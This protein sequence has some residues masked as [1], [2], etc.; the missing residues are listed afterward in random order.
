[1]PL[2]LL[3]QKQN[4]NWL[5]GTWLGM[6]FNSGQMQVIPDKASGMNSPY[7]SAVIS[8][9]KTGQLLC[10]TNGQ[11][12]WNKNNKV[13]PNGVLS[14]VVSPTS[15]IVPSAANSMQYYIFY[16]D[17]I[18]TIFYALVDMK[19]DNGLG[20]VIFKDSILGV[21]MDLQITGVR[22]EYGKGHWLITHKKGT[23]DFAVFALNNKGLNK[24][25]IVSLTGT[26][27]FISGNYT[28]GN[29]VTNNEGTKLIYT[30]SIMPSQG[31][32]MDAI[33]EVYDINKACGT[34]SAIIRLFPRLTGISD[35]LGSA[36]F[37]PTSK[38]VYTTASNANA[39]YSVEQYD[40]SDPDPNSTRETIGGTDFDSF[41][42]I[43]LAPDGRIYITI[44]DYGSATSEID[45]I[46][47][48]SVK[49]RDCNFFHR[50]IQLSKRPFLGS[51]YA[52]YFPNMIQDISKE[53]ESAA[54]PSLN[55]LDGCYGDSTLFVLKDQ[56]VLADSVKWDFGDG[57]FF[58]TLEHK[59]H[60]YTKTGVYPVSFSWYQCGI[61]YS[62]EDTVVIR[63]K[64]VLGFDNDTILCAGVS[65]TLNG[66]I[67][68]QYKWST[69]D[70]TR[71][72]IVKRPGVYSVKLGAT[73]CE[74]H[75]TISIQY[76]PD[77]W[78]LL[79]DEYFI[80][81]KENELVKLDAGEGF[82]TYKWLPT[83]D[84]TQW[85]NVAQ[86]KDYFV[87]VKDFRGCEGNDGTKVKRRCPVKVYFPNAFTPNNDNLNDVYLPIGN[88]VFE[89]NL[90]IY[91]AWG[92]QVFETNN[93][94]KGWDGMY[95]DE[96][97]PD[98]TYIYRSNYTG[99]RNKKLLSFNESGN[100]TLIR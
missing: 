58:A 7:R 12:V 78:T 21:G 60:T 25:P 48:P 71:E 31:Q 93:I 59:Y 34:I 76:R 77:I 99:Y 95:L 83:G 54:E 65:Y 90:T 46:K 22:Q 3:A 40:L 5:F 69:G 30:F 50:A 55:S 20:N 44:S 10:Y 74:L 62:V 45:V 67:A 19:L 26:A 70:I 1:M 37:D 79:G 33:T 39:A 4:N 66:G 64:P 72:I 86:I 97:A 6:T 63:I 2:M 51:I 24:T 29:L 49:G 11:K 88:D 81:D 47:N 41:G 36:C 87:I 75:D 35:M 17:N 73:G 27:T 92:Q 18:S 13:M 43:K 57:T 80:C 9:S 82:Q 85:I 23:A 38:F 91:N 68:D 84:T 52:E 61:A 96:H 98:G 42:D 56:P 100:I 14:S 53:N 32:F 8:D 15:L 94:L 89:F 28:Y 16:T